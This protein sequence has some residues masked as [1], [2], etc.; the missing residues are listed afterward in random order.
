[1][2]DSLFAVIENLTCRYRGSKMSAPLFAVIENL[3]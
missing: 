3:T 1:M 2:G